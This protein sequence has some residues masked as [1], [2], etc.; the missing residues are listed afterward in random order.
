MA[1]KEVVKKSNPHRVAVKN[2]FLHHSYKK[3]RQ[4]SR[5][6]EN[7]FK[8]QRAH[9]A[10]KTPLTEVIIRIEAHILNHPGDMQSRHALRR[11]QYSLRHG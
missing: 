5:T 7:M 3:D 10:S 8:R 9:K 11:K 1:K 6:T 2:S 4:R